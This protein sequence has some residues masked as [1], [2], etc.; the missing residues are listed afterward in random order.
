MGEVQTLTLG[1]IAGVAIFLGLPLGR[2]RS[3]RHSRTMPGTRVF[4]NAVALGILIFIVWDLLTQ[5]WGMI[6]ATLGK[7]QDGSGGVGPVIGLGA[8]CFAGLGVG[9]L[10]LAAY[11][12]WLIGDSEEPIS[13]GPGAM[14]ADELSIRATGSWTAA[15]RLALLTAVGIGLHNF[16][17]GLGV[18]SS[19]ARGEIA[20]AAL[21][22]VGFT[23]QNAAEGFGIV[24]PLAANDERGE[25]RFLLLLGLI[26]GGPT[27]LGTAVGHELTNDA[28]SMVFLT[29]AAGSILYVI[30]HVVAI[31][32]TGGHRHLLYWGVWA[33]L[34][35]GFVT[36]MLLTAG[37]A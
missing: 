3:P 1:L 13:L 2:L 36:D 23:L 29:L 21:L 33:G 4:L 34:V 16:G 11:E 35:G 31:A 15:H 27:V 10:S 30:I 12:R 26:G 28:V 19:A 24:A 14:A 5:A 6:G 7:V 22:L 32:L 18:G 37:G 20:L 17:E 8:L 25:W 9:L